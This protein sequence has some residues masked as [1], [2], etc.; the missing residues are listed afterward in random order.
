M[1]RNLSLTPEDITESAA[2]GIAVQQKSLD[3]LAKIVVN[4][5]ALDY[6]LD[7]QGG[8]CAVPNTTFCTWINSLRKLR[9]SYISLSKP[10]GLRRWL[11]QQG[12]SLIFLIWV[13]LGHGT[14]AS[15]SECLPN[16]GY[17]PA[18]NHSNSLPCV[19][20]SLKGY[21]WMHA[22]AGDQTNDLPLP[23][24]PKMPWIPVRD[25]TWHQHSQKAVAQSWVNTLNFDQ[26]SSTTESIDQKWGI[27]KGH[28]YIGTHRMEAAQ[29]PGPSYKSKPESAHM[30]W[31]HLTV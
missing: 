22:A 29:W 1:I 7:E 11:L 8:I 9:L 14:L 23:R 5:I 27:D 6:L 12:L 16:V 31:K 15:E 18:Y 20:C 19:L 3:S 26:Y 10:F 24:T 17:H 4:R 2:K 25:P 28:S 30:D 21:K 13:G